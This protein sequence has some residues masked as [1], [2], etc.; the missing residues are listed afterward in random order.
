MPLIPDTMRAV[1]L[2]E[3]GGPEKLEVET[4]KVPDVGP[5]EVLVEVHTAGVGVW[6]P[7]EREGGMTDYME[8]EPSFPYIPGSDGA[9]TVAATGDDVQRFDVGDPVFVFGFLNP[10]GGLYAEYAAL[11]ADRVAPLPDG[12]DLEQA[13][14][15]AVDGIT[16]LQG[17]GQALAI[18]EGQ[19]LLV[20]GASGGVGHLAVQI[21]R[22]TGARVLAVA[23]GDDGVALVQELGADAAVNGKGGDVA[24]AAERFA[25]E[26]VDA[27]LLLAGGPGREAAIAAVRD[28]GRVAWPNGVAAPELSDRLTGQAYDGMP[29][30]EALDALVELIEAGP[31]RVHVA[32]TF[33]LEQAADAHRAL[34]EHYLGKLA[35]DVRS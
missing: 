1:V 21:A 9:G 20:F 3:F 29:S 23:S 34:G 15:L 8:R 27:A 18:E 12:L 10:K 31:F 35:L 25:P 22:R 16:A 4:A 28:G 2:H 26:G 30:R 11:D 14:V 24:G 32:R 13:G 33:P 6:D 19:T 7:Y 17:L 5:D